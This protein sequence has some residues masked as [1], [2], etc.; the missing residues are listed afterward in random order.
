MKSLV[1][2]KPLI[3][4]PLLFAI[5][6]IL[7]LYAHNIGEASVGQILLPIVVS[8]GFTLLL[9]AI[10]SLI[11]KDV[12]KAGLATSLFLFFFFFYGRFYEL[13]EMWNVFVPQHEVLLFEILLLWGFCFYCIQIARKDFKNITKILNMVA[14]VLIIIPV[15]TI[16]SYQIM[17]TRSS[18]SKMHEQQS[19]VTV[20]PPKLN[21]MPDI[22]YIIL[23]EYAHPDTIREYYNYDN[24]QFIRNLENRGFFVAQESRTRYQET[25]SSI[26]SSLNMEH[27]TGKTKSKKSIYQKI[28]KNRVAEYLRSIGYQYIYIGSWADIGKYETGADRYYNFYLTKT[29]EG[30]VFNKTLADE[31]NQILLNTTMLKAVYFYLTEKFF[32]SNYRACTM[33][34][35]EQLKKIPFIKGSKFTFAH[36]M[37]PHEPFVFG[38]TGEHV[39]YANWYNYQDTQFYRGQYL[40]ITREIEKVVDALLKNSAIEPI[41][42]IQSDH[43]IKPYHIGKSGKDECRKI[44]NAYYLPGDGE[45]HLYE[46]ISPV[47]SFRV[48]LRHYFGATYKLLDD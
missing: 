4:Y 47:N 8:I 41:I 45:K 11:F 42:I 21:S 9:W 26:S 5:F 12:L 14:V 39:D 28:A 48:I 2:K 10:L 20:K 3:L 19:T 6:P 24:N 40:F 30:G 13:L 32:K 18:T 29:K 15:F 44:F 1:V 37:C 23:D 43:G 27:H 33:G 38:P 36:I 35:I 7:F 46:S 31:F 22:Y 16:A 25:F 17:Q 34:T